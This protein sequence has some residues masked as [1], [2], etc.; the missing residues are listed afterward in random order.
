MMYSSTV[1]TVNLKKRQKQKKK[2]GSAA[3]TKGVKLNNGVSTS[4]SRI[5]IFASWIIHV[6]HIC[7]TLINMTYIQQKNHRTFGLKGKDQPASLAGKLHGSIELLN[8][9]L[10]TIFQSMK[11]ENEQE[12]KERA[13]ERNSNDAPPPSPPMLP[14]R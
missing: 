3:L 2:P 7:H 9:G 1:S 13:R 5:Y 10:Y 14:A 11:V 4:S 6:L 12:P 8:V